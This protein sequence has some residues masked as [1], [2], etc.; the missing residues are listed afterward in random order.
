MDLFLFPFHIDGL[1]VAYGKRR[2]EM[3]TVCLLARDEVLRVA[4]VPAGVAAPSRAAARGPPGSAG[5]PLVR[6]CS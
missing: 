4:N 1:W 5:R 6:A 2:A 3:I